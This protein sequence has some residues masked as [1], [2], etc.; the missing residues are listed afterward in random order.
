M[1]KSPSKNVNVR[2]IDCHGIRSQLQRACTYITQ[3]ND[4]NLPP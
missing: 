3:P 2:G 1:F 4:V